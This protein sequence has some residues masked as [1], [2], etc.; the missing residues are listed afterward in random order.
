MKAF[1]GGF[2][3]FQIASRIPDDGD[4]G[5]AYLKGPN[6]EF[7]PPAAEKRVA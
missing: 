1:S 7:S 4:S 3:V 2:F 5:G 6:A